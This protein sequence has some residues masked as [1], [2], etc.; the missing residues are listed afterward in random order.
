MKG[1]V[2]HFVLR[3]CQR[4]VR[5]KPIQ[6]ADQFTVHDSPTAR[7]HTTTR[8]PVISGQTPSQLYDAIES[9]DDATD[10][11]ILARYAGGVDEVRNRYHEIRI[12]LKA[13][14]PVSSTVGGNDL[15]DEFESEGAVRITVG[16]VSRVFELGGA[17]ADEPYRWTP[18]NAS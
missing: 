10:A 8:L 18:S 7:A 16:S 15:S 4:D 1:G 5:Y 3:G 9:L 6:R 14:V 17:D 11:E 13:T 2:R 12:R